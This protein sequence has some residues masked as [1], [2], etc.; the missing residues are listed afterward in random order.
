MN[1]QTDALRVK[2]KPADAESIAAAH[3]RLAQ[4]AEWTNSKA[5]KTILDKDGAPTTKLLAYCVKEELN[6][7]WLFIGDVKALALAERRHRAAWLDCTEFDDRFARLG[8]LLHALRILSRQLSEADGTEQLDGELRGALI[9]VIEAAST[10]E[11]KA[12]NAYFAAH[13]A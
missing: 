13:R 9:V 12:T 2:N 7:D 8:S 1:V 5:P 4:F 3:A 10:Q 11:K 6:L